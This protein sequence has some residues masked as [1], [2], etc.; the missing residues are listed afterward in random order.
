LL[1]LGVTFRLPGAN[2]RVAIMGRTGSGKTTFAA[3]LLSQADFHRKP[4]VI[5]DYKGEEIFAKLR[6]RASDAITQIKVKDRA[7]TRPGLHIVNPVPAE[8]DEAMEDF[9]WRIW[10]RGN[11]G[12]YIDEAHLMPHGSQSM[13]AL[14]VT[15]RSRKI[16]MMVISQ[17]PVW[18]PREVFSESNR[19]VAFDIV[20]RDDR[21][22]IGEF[23]SLNGE[24]IPRMP[25]YHSLYHDVDMNERHHVLPAPAGDESIDAILRRAPRRFRW[26]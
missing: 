24:E 13:K 22:L 12:V 19:H 8:D 21:K 18:V 20:R 11:T 26:L 1:V 7:P 9:L 23:V 6:K 14:L 3:W 10:E 17:R 2:D 5:I 25:S 4:W 15:G 16:P